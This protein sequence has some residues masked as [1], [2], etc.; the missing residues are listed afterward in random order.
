MYLFLVQNE[1]WTTQYL[2]KCQESTDALKAE[3]DY[4]PQSYFKKA[5]EFAFGGPFFLAPA[6]KRNAHWLWPPL[7]AR[8]SN[9]SRWR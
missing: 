7:F 2:E 5:P 4:C 6:V 8:N 9:R 1:R 3:V